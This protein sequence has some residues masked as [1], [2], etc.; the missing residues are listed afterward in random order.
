MK[1]ITSLV[2]GSLL[3]SASLLAQPAPGKAVRSDA[4]RDLPLKKLNLTD[5]QKAQLQKIRFDTEKKGIELKAKLELSQLELHNLLAAETPDQ[6]ALKKKIEEVAQNGAALHTNRLNGWFEAN[7]T[8][9][10]EQQKVWREVLRRQEKQH[11]RDRM[12]QMQHGAPQK[13]VPA[14][15]PVPQH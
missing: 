8:F 14:P 3:L 4:I 6:P 12:R 15:P 2:V 11:M 1:W 7:K 10:L 13:N 9:N 5:D